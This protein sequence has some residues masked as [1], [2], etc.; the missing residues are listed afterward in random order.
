MIKEGLFE[1][2]YFYYIREFTKVLFLFYVAFKIVL[3]GPDTVLP[4][5]F[6]AFIHAFGN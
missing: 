6:A 2:C 4:V 3:S 1:P 5:I